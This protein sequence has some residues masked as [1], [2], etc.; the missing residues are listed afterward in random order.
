MRICIA[1]VFKMACE[2]SVESSVGGIII[3]LC[4]GNVEKMIKKLLYCETKVKKKNSLD[5]IE[6]L[7]S[8]LIWDVCLSSIIETT[9]HLLCA[10]TLLLHA[11]F[12]FFVSTL[13]APFKTDTYF[14]APQS[15]YECF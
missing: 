6:R 2:I 1:D 8:T 15:N 3:V 13:C 4:M 7:C 5:K 11:L 14:T 10:S 9:A 12:L